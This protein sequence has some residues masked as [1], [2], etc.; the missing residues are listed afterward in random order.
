LHSKHTRTASRL[1]R[2]NCLDHDA[3]GQF[4][5]VRID[6][7]EGEFSTMCTKVERR[8]RI[9]FTIS[10]K[11]TTNARLLTNVS[12]ITRKYKTNSL[13]AIV[14]FKLLLVFVNNI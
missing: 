4:I 5:D 13:S 2:D 8:L 10:T 1:E 6:S 9:L 7:N 12:V 14:L 11:A 3:Q